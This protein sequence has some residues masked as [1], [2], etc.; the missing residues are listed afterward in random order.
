MAIDPAVGKPYIFSMH[1]V[2]ILKLNN[3]QLYIGFTR[4]LK[5]RLKEHESGK[6]FSTKKYLPIELIYYECYSAF[7]DAKNRESK[8]KQFGSTYSQ[9]KKRIA[10]SIGASQRRG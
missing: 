4:D 10:H 6:V 1:F 3:G 9:L 8:I 2:Y 7:L 5:K